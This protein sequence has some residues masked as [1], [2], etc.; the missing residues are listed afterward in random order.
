[1]FKRKGGGRKGIW[2]YLLGTKKV[3]GHEYTIINTSRYCGKFLILREGYFCSNHYHNQKDETFFVLEGKVQ[4]THDGMITILNEGD[5]KR[6]R[7]QEFHTFLGIKDSIILEISTHHDDDD[8][9]R[10]TVSDK[11][12]VCYVDLDGFLCTNAKGI[13]R[14]AKPI[15]QNIKLINE[16]Y[17]KGELIIIWTARGTTTGID[18]RDLT[19]RQLSRW[20]VSY[21]D[22][23]FGKPEFDEIYDDKA[24]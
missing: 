7:P 9:I 10:E 16:K 19:E 8:S 17:E 13:Y 5:S 22:L 18:W 2:R 14:K 23:R 24:R 11:A 3:W 20:G 1:M 4:L 15:Q 21:H 12:K 6:I